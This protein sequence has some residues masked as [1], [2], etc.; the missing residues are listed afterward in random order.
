MET[1]TAQ[2]AQPTFRRYKDG[3]FN[4]PSPRAN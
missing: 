4:G 1:P 2:S 3:D